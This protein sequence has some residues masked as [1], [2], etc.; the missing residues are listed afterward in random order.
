VFSKELIGM[1][2]G[3]A[4]RFRNLAA[5]PFVLAYWRGHLCTPAGSPSK[6]DAEQRKSACEYFERL[7]YGVHR[8]CGRDSTE[9]V[10]GRS[11]DHLFWSENRQQASTI[12]GKI[13]ER[14]EPTNFAIVRAY[15]GYG[16][17]MQHALA[18]AGI[19]FHPRAAFPRIREALDD[20][21]YATG[22]A[23]RFNQLASKLTA[24]AI[25]G[26]SDECALV[27]T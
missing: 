15:V 5:A 13:A 2:T 19:D 14:M 20:L 23:Q 27:G 6:V 10:G 7:W 26:G 22:R 21:V 16:W 18:M 24:T 3:H 4:K 1:D 17:P 25:T 8:T 12:L 9:I 11:S